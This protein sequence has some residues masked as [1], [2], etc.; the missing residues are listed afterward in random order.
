MMAAHTQGFEFLSALTYDA[1][2]EVMDLLSVQELGRFAQV[3]KEACT[4]ATD[5]AVWRRQC[6]SLEPRWAS[7]IQPRP[8]S[9]VPK[10]QPSAQWM[11]AFHEE[12]ERLEF[13]SKF[14]GSWSEK[15]CDVNVINSTTIETDGTN[16]I[17]T[18]KKNKFSATLRG[19]E[20][21]CLSFN[22][23]GGDSGWSFL[24]QVRPLS[25]SMLHLS[26]TRIHDQKVFCGTFTRHSTTA[27]ATPE[28][29]TADADPMQ[30]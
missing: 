20:A 16:F 28:P 17:V 7:L 14:V 26:V 29:Q 27:P 9:M 8:A 11:D 21:D 19:I 10:V 24:Y 6:R 2:L 5:D 18:Y 23:E 15:W 4:L 25:E 13:H 3:S 22:L 12:R 30:L 1:M